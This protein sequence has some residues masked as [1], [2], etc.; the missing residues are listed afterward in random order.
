MTDEELVTEFLSRVPRETSKR[1]AWLLELIG[2]VRKQ[3][4]Q[5]KQKG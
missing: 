3:E 2:I 1:K 4:R 5:E